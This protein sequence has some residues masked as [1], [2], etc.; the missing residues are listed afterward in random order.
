MTKPDFNIEDGS[1][2]D[3][4]TELNE[5]L[6]A[7][8]RGNASTSE[9]LK[10]E[11]G[12]WWA[13]LATDRMRQRNSSNDAWI[14]L[15]SLST[16]IS[17][18]ESGAGGQ[19]SGPGKAWAISNAEPTHPIAGDGWFSPSAGEL[20]IF[21]GT[22]WDLIGLPLGQGLPR[23]GNANDVLEKVDGVDY[24]AR[25]TQRT[26]SS[27]N[28][29]Q[30]VHHNFVLMDSG[31]TDATQIEGNTWTNLKQ[32]SS[33]NLE[34]EA[35]PVKTLTEL[36]YIKTAGVYNFGQ[37][38]EKHIEVETKFQY[39]VT[40]EIGD[41][42][43]W[44]SWEDVEPGTVE[45]NIALRQKLVSGASSRYRDIQPFMENPLIAGDAFPSATAGQYIKF[46]M[47]SRIPFGSTSWI[48][49]RYG[50][51][52][53]ACVIST[54][55]VAGQVAD[56]SETVK[57]GVLISNATDN[58]EGTNTAKAVSPSGVRS[59][60]E[61]AFFTSSEYNFVAGTPVTA[62]HNLGYVPATY[63][64]VLRCKIAEGGYAVGREL[65]ISMKRSANGG[66]LS[67]DATNLYAQVGDEFYNA[68]GGN[69]TL[70][71]AN[72]RWVFYGW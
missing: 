11:P 64:A 8:N 12:T 58:L 26:L 61:N 27:D 9:P 40:D 3:V 56:A 63:R 4:L 60:F 42:V 38:I 31:Y 48:I 50:F 44:S 35:L 29:V 17:A 5:N 49:S 19:V 59:M 25:W 53:D 13:D 47:Q 62:S 28:S 37:G 34:T 24:N 2:S 69:L 65:D 10:V 51:Y 57:G 36:W 14:N 1:F 55:E 67:A 15:Y 21:D 68:T 23:S 46:R 22:V 18:G 54:K 30:H 32:N 70:T 33:G 52:L 39:S 71:P 6:D 43:S 45:N 41:S 72:W 7:A 20:K 66:S 16:G